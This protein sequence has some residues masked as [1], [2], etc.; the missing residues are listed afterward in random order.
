VL[1]R[2]NIVCSTRDTRYVNIVT[3]LEISHE[4]FLSF[5]FFSPRMLGNQ[6]SAYI[7]ICLM[8]YCLLSYILLRCT[9]VPIN[10]K[11]LQY[12]AD[13]SNDTILVTCFH[14]PDWFPKHFNNT[15]CTFRNCI[16]SDDRSQLSK[17]RAV[18]FYHRHLGKI[19][20]KKKLLISYGLYLTLK[21]H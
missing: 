14:R 5:F 19:I 4:L 11:V 2:L 1:R 12:T 15:Q 20:P 7:A 17:S 16:F 3:N 18:L 10:V 8:L 21:V 9:R 13:H 6:T